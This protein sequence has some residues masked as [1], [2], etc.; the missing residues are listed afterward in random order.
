MCLGLEFDNLIDKKTKTNYEQ[1][2]IK[3]THEEKHVAVLQ[4]T[5]KANE[6]GGGGCGE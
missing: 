2:E 6:R 5:K 4:K 3:N 1:V